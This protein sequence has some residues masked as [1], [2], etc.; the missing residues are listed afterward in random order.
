[1]IPDT[2]A[3]TPREVIENRENE[4]VDNYAQYCSIV[5]TGIGK[6][7]L[8]IGGEVDAGKCYL[9]PPPP[10]STSLTITIEIEPTHPIPSLGFQTR[11][12]HPAHKLGRAENIRNASIR[13]RHAKIRA[14]ITQIL[15]PIFSP[16]RPQNHRWLSVQGWDIGEVGGIGDERY[17][18]HG[19]E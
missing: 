13:P 8:I 17:P 10:S 2:W 4:I 12:P 11:Q 16:R 6:S 1:M 3:A 14:Q 18:R 15:D 9:I 7:K 5:K 19:E